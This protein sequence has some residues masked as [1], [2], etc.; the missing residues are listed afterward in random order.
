MRVVRSPDGVVRVDVAGCAP[1][2]G[3]YLCVNAEC[4]RM[5]MKKNAL[6]KALKHPV[7]SGIYAFLK[8][9]ALERGTESQ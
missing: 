4:I 3:A 5:A 9:I 2:R 8:R 6:T 1:G 7:D